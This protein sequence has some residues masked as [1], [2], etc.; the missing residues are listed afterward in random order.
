MPWWDHPP[1]DLV[2]QPS[3]HD[4]PRGHVDRRVD[5]LEPLR[6]MDT[7]RAAEERVDPLP[8]DDL[9]FVGFRL[10]HPIKAEAARGVGPGGDGGMRPRVDALDEVA[11]DRLAGPLQADD[12]DDRLGRS[13]DV[14][15]VAPDELASL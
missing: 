7:L 4:H 12:A 1:N 9:N 10:R 3:G 15:E 5:R 6:V 8:R 13:G 11:F 2:D 14:V